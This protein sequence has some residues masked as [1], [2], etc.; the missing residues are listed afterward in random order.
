AL[1]ARFLDDAEQQHSIIMGCYGIGVNR[2]LAGLIETKHDEQGIVW[3]MSLAPYEVILAPLNV[4][5]EDVMQVAEK[6][7]ETLAAAGVDVLLDDR[8]QRAGVKFKDA[9]L[10][11]IPLRVVIGGRSFKDGK[12][13]VKWRWEAEPILIDLD[14]AAETL[15]QMVRAARDAAFPLQNLAQSSAGSC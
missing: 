15:D 5:Q 10:I 2:I 4:T 7:H 6:L 13:E 14:G 1:Q 9:D 11:G 3:P 8:D 12:L